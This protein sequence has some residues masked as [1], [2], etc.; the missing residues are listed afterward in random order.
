MCD[1][2]GICKPPSDLKIW[3]WKNFIGSSAGILKDQGVNVLLNIFCGPTVNAA[4]G[5]AVQVNTAVIQFS[6][7]FMTAINPQI[8]KSYATNDIKYSTALVYQ[9]A[10]YSYF[11]LFVISLPIIIKTEEIVTLWLGIVPE[12]VISFIR[13]ILIGAIID[14][15][16][17]GIITLMLATG[18][19]RNYQIA[20]GCCTL[21]N[22]PLSYLFLKTGYSPE[23]VFAVS[24]FISICCLAIRI[25]MLNKMITFPLFHFVSQVI[26]PASAVSIVAITIIYGAS[27]LIPTAMSGL[28]LCTILTFF[29][30]VA[31]TFFIGL[32]K[33]EREYIIR[34]VNGILK[35]KR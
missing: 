2:T 20:V 14:S 4:R 11:M 5:I 16:S 21:L 17:N 23:L 18:K 13:L 25:Y 32:K 35:H 15:L 7:N 29:I 28:I 9:S 22:F 3:V 10:R 33:T 6:Q 30:T 24:I 26:L 8:T 1:Q 34:K 27:I 19:I 12:H 31:T